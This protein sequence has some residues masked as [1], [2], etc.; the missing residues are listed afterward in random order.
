M[1]DY[2]KIKAFTIAIILLINNNLNSMGEFVTSTIHRTIR[3]HPDEPSVYPVLH[4]FNAVINTERD[5]S[6][7]TPLRTAVAYGKLHATKYLIA[8]GA[9]V[10]EPDH[11]TGPII[12]HAAVQ[13]HPTTPQIVDELLPHVDNLDAE[14]Y[15]NKTLLEYLEK[16]HVPKNP[17]VISAIK[18]ELERRRWSGLRTQWATAVV[19][20]AHQSY[21]TRPVNTCTDIV[22][23]QAPKTKS[24]CTLM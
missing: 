11:V 1:E 23:Y 14:I 5:L 4:R 22:P 16:Y 6:K 2:M 20:T 9:N 7:Y 8:N 18:A 17:A 15:F 3:Y 19:L 21:G 13:K 24:C 12:F 10:N